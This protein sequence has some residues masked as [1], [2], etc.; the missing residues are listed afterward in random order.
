VQTFPNGV[1]YNGSWVG[2]TFQG[3]GVML[4][5]S[6]GAV[7]EGEWVGDLKHGLGVFNWT[8]R[9]CRTLVTKSGSRELQGSVDATKNVPDKRPQKP[10]SSKS[11]RVCEPSDSYAGEWKNNWMHGVGVMTSAKG[12]RYV[13]EFDSGKKPAP[14]CTSHS[15]ASTQ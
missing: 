8:A 10:P 4:W 7:Y 13:G 2:D 15:M 9:L 3:H 11:E 14:H 12:R 1:V 6:S 5:P